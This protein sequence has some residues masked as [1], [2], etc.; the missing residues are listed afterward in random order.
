MR[1]LIVII[2]FMVFTFHSVGVA[3]SFFGPLPLT[4]E[5][6][7]HMG[8]P[9]IH[10][11]GD[12]QIPYIYA[13]PDIPGGR[14]S[15]EEVPQWNI[16][17]FCDAGVKQFYMTVFFEQMW[18]EDGTFDITPARK[19]VQGVQEVCPGAALYLRFHFHMPEWWRDQNP[20]E[21][22][23]Y[24]DVDEYQVGVDYGFKRIIDDDFRAQRRESL[25]SKKWMED[26]TRMT[27]RFIDEF[28]KTPEAQ[29]LVGLHIAGAVYG[30]WHYWGFMYNEP[31]QSEAMHQWF[32]EWLSQK[33]GTDK[34]LQKAWGIP[35]ATIAGARV[36][37]MKD[38]IA[39][40]GLF[41]D[42]VSERWVGD[43]YRAQ[44]EL[45]TNRILHYAQVVKTEWKRPIIVGTFWGYFFSVFGRDAAGGHLDYHKVLESPHIDFVSAPQ[46][47]EPDDH[48][49]GHPY[50]SR[51]LMQS[52]RLHGKVWLDEMDQQPV[53]LSTVYPNYRSE[54]DNSIAVMQR[55]VLFSLTKGTGLWY[56]DFG[57]GGVL[58]DN[59][60]QRHRGKYGWWDHP[61]LIADV[62]TI[63]KVYEDRL[64]K[65]YKPEAD[66]LFVYDTEVFF[67]TASRR[68]SDALTNTA[69]NWS[70][71][72]A[73]YSGAAFETVHLKDLP[74]LDL[75]PYKVI[76]FGN[77]YLMDQ[78]KI[79]SIQKLVANNNRHIVWFYGPG[80]T[81]GKTLDVKRVSSATGITMTIGKDAFPFPTV[82]P[83]TTLM[84]GA[85]PYT[86]KKYWGRPDTTLSPMFIPNDPKATIFAKYDHD[87][88][89]ALVMKPSKNHTSWH[90][91]LPITDAVTM[92]AI[93]EKAGV[94][95]YT[96]RTGEVVYAGNGLVVY[97]SKRGGKHQLRFKNGTV[98]EFE[99]PETHATTLLFDA[100]TGEQICLNPGC[101]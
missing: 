46:V 92:R 101:L 29:Y 84:P 67:H 54:L 61:E 94:H 12:P 91:S 24:T 66:V 32:R 97:H 72:A 38:R 90:A 17:Q 60:L 34:E 95:L 98:K 8:S 56:F 57:P 69:I 44:H 39:K 83:D 9:T 78:A 70:T 37:D 48:L 3:Q 68:F 86:L 45:V 52:V 10:I 15:W 71:L 18:F 7:S 73:H 21:M 51:G 27:K 85:K 76:I 5:V 64:N 22:T 4:G 16:K 36:P 79:A 28:Q 55:N 53:L 19:Q 30:E 99:L 80:Y 74:K 87:N 65:P 50:R 47:Y 25:A 88:S 1:S 77:T 42:P 89:P 81:D 58:F 96:D 100:A 62:N 75:S 40:N 93:F 20:Q 31:D 6:K 26:A 13:L 23:V 49:P 14:F 43:Y 82:L 2:G 33:Y 41:R 63:R 35:N 59:P 11:N